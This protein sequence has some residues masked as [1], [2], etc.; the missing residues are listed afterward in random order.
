MTPTPTTPTRNTWSVPSST[1]STIVRPVPSSVAPPPSPLAW[2]KADGD[3]IMAAVQTRIESES[4]I[5]GKIVYYGKWQQAKDV[6][7]DRVP[8]LLG[9]L[10]RHPQGETGSEGVLAEQPN[11][12]K[13]EFRSGP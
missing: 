11:R 8:S 6:S 9:R 4:Y 10:R 3:Q 7:R 1:A 5:A 13:G 2:W 12:I